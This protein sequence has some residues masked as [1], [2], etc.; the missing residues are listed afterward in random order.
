METIELLNSFN[1][2]IKEIYKEF[3]LDCINRLDD[4]HKIHDKQML[5]WHSDIARRCQ[6]ANNMHFD[7]FKNYD[8][9]SY[10]SD[11]ILYFVAHLYLY[12]PYLN[13]PIEDKIWFSKRF[14]YPNY[15]NIG[16]K[17]Y[18]MFA[19]IVSEK[20]YNYWDRIGDLIASFFPE[21]I[22]EKR[23]FFATAF[24]VIPEEFQDLDSYKW[25][26]E[27]RFNAYQD[28][29]GKRKEVVH[30]TTS[31]NQD[32]WEH[33]KLDTEEKILAWL[34]NRNSMADYFRE[35]IYITIEGFY[36]TLLLLE[37]VDKIKY[38]NTIVPS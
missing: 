1:T 25:L 26:K 8:E 33:L 7:Y 37:K 10:C 15:V 11:E 3:E 35:H 21:L 17:R 12:K 6:I 19:D 18:Y 27:F 24:D 4:S 31:I 28:L 30:Y 23:V 22:S 34:K 14:V 9:L 36:Q 16:T 13:N 20:L 5:S 32:K 38:G 2:K 29:N